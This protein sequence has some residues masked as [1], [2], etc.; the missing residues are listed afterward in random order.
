[1]LRLRPVLAFTSL[2][3]TRAVRACMSSDLIGPI[4]VRLTMDGRSSESG[5]TNR[6]RD[7]NCSPNIIRILGHP[8]GF[9]TTNLVGTECLHRLGRVLTEPWG[10][11]SSAEPSYPKRAYPPGDLATSGEGRLGLAIYIYSLLIPIG[12]VAAVHIFIFY[13]GKR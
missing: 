4:R 10:W 7:I 12:I 3:R 2:R 11:V 1:V 5:S 6:W 8:L 13:L 9:E